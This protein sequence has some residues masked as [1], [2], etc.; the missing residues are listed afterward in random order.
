MK[1][2][3]ATELEIRNDIALIRAAIGQRV[4]HRPNIWGVYSNKNNK[5]M[6]LL[7]D[8]T[9]IQAIL[10]EGDPRVASYHVGGP[11]WL[12]GTVDQENDLG[13]ELHIQYRDGTKEWFLCG[14][15][16]NLIKSPGKVIKQ[17]MA[18]REVA[19]AEEGVGFSVRTERDFSGR[20]TEFRNWLTLC[21]AMTRAR[22][23]SRDHEV[24]K[25][26][27]LLDRHDVIP[28]KDALG[29]EG[30]DQALMIAGIAH[31]LANGQLHCDLK[32][33][34][35]TSCTTIAV[36]QLSENCS[37]EPIVPI[38]Q[39]APDRSIPKTRRTAVVPELWRCLENWPT[40]IAELVGNCSIYRSRKQA[41]EM[42]LHDRSFDDIL[43]L[44][45]NCASWVRKLVRK[46]LQEAPDGRIWGFRALIKYRH[47]AIYRRVAPLPDSNLFEGRRGAFNGAF[48]QLLSRFPDQLLTFVEDHVLKCRQ[49]RVVEL[50][51]AKISWK[52]LHKKF[53]GFL[54]ENG[55]SEN[56]Y[57]FNTRG[58][59]YASIVRLCNAILYRKPIAFINARGGREAGRLVQTGQGIPSLIQATSCFQIVELD[60][61]KID[62]AAVVDI[63]TPHGNVV[64]A[65]V[66]RWWIGAMV[67]IHNKLLLGS[68]DSFEYQ[69]SEPCVLDLVDSAVAPRNQ[70]KD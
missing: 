65:P 6:T 29:I 60:F 44:T 7:G 1:N 39:I 69:T 25:L 28:I 20:M 58:K 53:I 3:L 56:E 14:R 8:V 40:P 57:P 38:A 19:A 54:R 43:E 13:R 64:N 5:L 23:F 50:P 24:A 47:N 18:A 59:G 33:H 49:K 21:A 32:N 27:E 37:Y 48:N 22:D 9:F 62:S 36:N 61:H 35:I 42:Y 26:L 52:N 46:C 41:V 12:G 17:H 51:E 34:P 67:D 4:Y 63:K 16:E 66:A 15:Y 30:I 31:W 2:Q 45:G 55:V 10:L 68:S 11:A 70:P